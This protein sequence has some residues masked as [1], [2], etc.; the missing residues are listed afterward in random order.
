MKKTMNFEKWR[1]K[2]LIEVL[3]YEGQTW[4]DLKNPRTKKDLATVTTGLRVGVPKN[5]VAIKNYSENT[6]VLDF[7]IEAGVIELPAF[8]VPSGFVN[9]PVCKLLV[10]PTKVY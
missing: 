6:G 3:E 7:L 5:Y 9:I 1:K 10:K 4:I 2:V 8:Y